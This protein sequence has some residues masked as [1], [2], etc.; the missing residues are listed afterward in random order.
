MTEFELLEYIEHWAIVN[1]NS[2]GYIDAIALRREI[3][4][5]KS[6]MPAFGYDVP[7]RAFD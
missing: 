7:D 4:K 5:I 2:D 6:K 1:M 3:N